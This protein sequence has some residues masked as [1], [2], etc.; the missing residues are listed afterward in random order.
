[1]IET[2]HTIELRTQ[3]DRA[4]LAMHLIPLSGPWPFALAVRTPEEDS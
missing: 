1:M 2:S 3:R 4:T